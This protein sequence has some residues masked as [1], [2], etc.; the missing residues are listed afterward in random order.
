LRISSVLPAYNEELNIEKS[1][2]SNIN[3]FE[4]NNII[5]WEII[6]IN[7]G[8]IDKTKSIVENIILNNKRVKLIN[9]K[10]NKGY[11]ETL[12]SGLLKTK[13]EWVFITDSDLQFYIND[14]K[15]FISLSKEY[16]FIQGIRGIRSDSKYRILLGKIYKKIM[17][18]FFNIPVSDPECSFRLFKRELIEN[19]NIICSGPMVPI[20]LILSAKTNNARFKE[21]EVRHR[22]REYGETN[23]LSF[24]TFKK[25]LRDFYNLFFH[26]YFKKNNFI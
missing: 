6:I 3:F 18:I 7:D 5:D 9:H 2:F 1:I 8:S 19:I 20:E 10:I 21:V 22:S 12:Y 14:L 13:F 24:K 16:T 26:I 4:N 11:G 17:N 23:A 15:N 25:T